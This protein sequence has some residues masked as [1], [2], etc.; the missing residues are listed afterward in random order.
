MKNR[1]NK[2]FTFTQKSLDYIKEI[3]ESRDIKYISD[4]LEVIINEHQKNYNCSEEHLV[5][6]ISDIVSERV[7]K[8]VKGDIAEIEKNVLIM[9]EMLNGMFFK[10]N[11]KEIVTTSEEMCP[12][13]KIAIQ[14]VNKRVEN[15]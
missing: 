6:A 11:Y 15:K 7:E 1:Y 13:L 12:G 2:T 9:I 5:Q 3:R 10:N 8:K 4:A 14:E